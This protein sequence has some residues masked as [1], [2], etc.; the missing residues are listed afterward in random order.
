MTQFDANDFICQN[1]FRVIRGHSTFVLRHFL[2]IR[3]IRGSIWESA[4]VVKK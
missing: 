2:G 1:F 3:E 4:F